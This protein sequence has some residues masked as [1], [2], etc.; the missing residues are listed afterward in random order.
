MDKDAK[1]KQII[2]DS[3]HLMYLQGYNATNI[4]EIASMAGMGKSTFYGYFVS[5]EEYAVFALDY[6]MD[7][8][9]YERFKL[10]EDKK[11]DPIIRI[12]NFYKDKIKN[13]EDVEYKLGCFIGNLTQEMADVNSSI[14]KATNRLHDKIASK[15]LV[16]LLEANER[17]N[18]VQIIEPKIMA[19][20]II[21]SWQGALIRMKACKNRVPLDEFYK[22]LDEVLL[23]FQKA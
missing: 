19:D 14:A 3:I 12:K 23:N 20:F 4:R 8:L 1:R 18:I 16:C 9:N 10:L 22:I 2:K 17:Y 15:I 13:M 11:V 7:I 21:N 6:Y 5:K